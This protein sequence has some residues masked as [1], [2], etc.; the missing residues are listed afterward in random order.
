MVL[1]A[2]D[3]IPPDFTSILRGFKN[4]RQ[5]PWRSYY[6]SIGYRTWWTQEVLVRIPMI[7]IISICRLCQIFF[8]FRLFFSGAFSPSHSSKNH[9]GTIVLRSTKQKKKKNV[10]KN[11][12]RIL[13]FINNSRN[14]IRLTKL[15]NNYL[16]LYRPVYIFVEETVC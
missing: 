2:V 11:A 7:I 10:L 4:L 12:C 14:Y 15:L 13:W 5:T 1:L 16:K 6:L 8:K 3:H 9:N